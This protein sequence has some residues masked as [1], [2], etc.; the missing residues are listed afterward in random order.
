M[1]ISRR[2]SSPDKFSRIH[3]LSSMQY[4]PYCVEELYSILYRFCA[5]MMF[6]FHFS[7]TQCSCVA[8][9]GKVAKWSD[10]APFSGDSLESSLP[11]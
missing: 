10:Y 9:R 8:G 5:F 1:A 4:T 3:I 6:F 2:A 11:G 7:L